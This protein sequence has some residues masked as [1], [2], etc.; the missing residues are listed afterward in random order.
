MKQ[1]VPVSFVVH[2]SSSSMASCWGNRQLPLLR[3]HPKLNNYPSYFYL[4]YTAGAVLRH[5]PSYSNVYSFHCRRGL[6]TSTNLLQRV[7][8]CRRGL[9][10]SAKLLQ[11]VFHCRRGLNT[12]AKLLQCVF[13]C[14]RGLK[15]SAKLLQRV[16]HCRRVL[17]T[18]TKVVLYHAFV[19]N[20]MT[21]VSYCE[22][23]TT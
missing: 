23:W 4:D 11:R 19:V 20:V 5:S 18:L 13:H 3:R 10:T 15:T 14:R 22:S 1:T 6:N 8:H 21:F 16:F 9:K 17:K 7:F 12:S 2:Q